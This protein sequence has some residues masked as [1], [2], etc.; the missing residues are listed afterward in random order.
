MLSGNEFHSYRQLIIAGSTEYVAY[1]S[2]WCN[3]ELEKI[4]FKFT[5]RVL[6]RILKCYFNFQRFEKYT[7]RD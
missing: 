4:H 5:Q 6:I 2:S 3:K 7:E 1:S